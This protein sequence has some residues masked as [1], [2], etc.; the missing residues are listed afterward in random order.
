[1]TEPF[2]IWQSAEQMTGDERAAW[3]D[4]CAAEA[5]A[6]GAKHARFSVHPTNG[7]V[8]VEAWKERPIADGALQE[9]DPRWQ[10]AP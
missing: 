3:F 6:E 10:V 7:W 4:K 2:Y 9:G 8:L 1:M 5:K